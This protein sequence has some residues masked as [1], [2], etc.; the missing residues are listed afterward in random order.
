MKKPSSEPVEKPLR[1]LT[2]QQVC[3]RT[4]LSIAFIN[5]RIKDGTFPKPFKLGTYRIVF[6]EEDIEDWMRLQF[7]QAQNPTSDQK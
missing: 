2:M 4:T 3:D 1:F 7:E 5:P 6:R